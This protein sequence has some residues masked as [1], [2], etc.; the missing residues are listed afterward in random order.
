M[1]LTGKIIR[2]QI[3]AELG[4]PVPGAVHAAVEVLRRR[5]GDAI[6]G[7]LF[8]GSSLRDGRVEGRVLD[9]Y[10]L[11]RRYREFHAT[12]LAAASNRLLPPNVYYLETEQAGRPV[13]AKYAVLSIDHLLSG[14]R[15]GTTQTSIWARFAQPCALVYASGPE[16]REAV[17]EALSS[18]A[19]T[20]MFET[21][22]LVGSDVSPRELWQRAFRETY[23]TEF[24]AERGNRP[25]DLYAAF[26]ERYDRI[27]AAVLASAP[28]QECARARRRCAR[29]WRMRRIAGRTLHVLRLMK[30]V[31]TFAGGLDYILWKIESHSGV[32]VAATPWQRRHPLLAA[33]FI[34][35]RLYRRGGF[36]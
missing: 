15:P 35:T 24:R 23:R 14:T 6:A 30:A 3:G 13:R 17:L 19:A 4:Q 34:A 29:G 33:P 12:W 28:A 22:P 21:L 18:A 10:V 36:R 2:S 9:F 5:H 32:R 20:M 31:F 25:H 27:G 16:V 7:I 26:P 8:Y 11:V 1:G